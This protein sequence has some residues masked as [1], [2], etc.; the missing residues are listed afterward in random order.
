MRRRGALRSNP[1]KTVRMRLRNNIMYVSMMI[2]WVKCIF[3]K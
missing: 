2:T 1:N 3:E